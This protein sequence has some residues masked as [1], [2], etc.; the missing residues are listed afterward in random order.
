MSNTQLMSVIDL[1][2]GAMS[3]NAVILSIGI[4]T[5][6]AITFEQVSNLYISV[7]P[8]CDDNAMREW[9]NSTR[10]WWLSQSDQAREEAMRVSG[11]APLRQAIATVQQYIK[12]LAKEGEV[13]VFGNGSEF[14]ISILTSA[15]NQL[16]VTIPWKFANAQSIR[17]IVWLGRT[18]FGVDFKKGAEFEGVEH[19]ALCDSKHE[20]SYAAKTLAYIK[21]VADSHTAKQSIS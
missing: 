15:F 6:N 21:G 8:Y 16:D 11:A 9:D 12:L 17:T 3:A 19:N 20:A 10:S 5:I 18:Y 7:N 13:H 2:T 14:D 1:K 4:T